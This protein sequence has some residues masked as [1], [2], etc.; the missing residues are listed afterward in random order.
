[1]CNPHHVSDISERNVSR[2]QGGVDV[3]GNLVIRPT[4][5]EIVADETP[6]PGKGGLVVRRPTEADGA[7]LRQVCV[8]GGIGSRN[9]SAANQ[10]GAGHKWD[11][12]SG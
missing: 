5:A 4:P 7:Q 2:I 3:L 9:R 12:Q 1:M 8:V 11:G 10:G 6:H